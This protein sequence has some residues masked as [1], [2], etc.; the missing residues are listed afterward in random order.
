MKFR[1]LIAI[2]LAFVLGGATLAEAQKRQEPPSDDYLYDLV[3]RRLASD[4][5]VKG[6]ALD[7]EVNEGA[8]TLK[9]K[10]ELEKQKERA[11][12]IVR[13][14]KGVRSV[15]NQLEVVGRGGR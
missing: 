7:V 15:D 4:P 1:I 5:V 8:V 12:R 9:G 10:V 13:K 3:R 11:T 2:L 6:G 14:I